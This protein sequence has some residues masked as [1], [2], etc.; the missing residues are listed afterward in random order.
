VH[1]VL[2]KIGIELGDFVAIS[3]PGPIGLLGAQVAKSAGA[4]YVLISGT[5]RD[6]NIR[7]KLASKLGIDYILNVDSQDPVSK[8]RKLTNGTGVDVVIEASGSPLAINQAFQMVRRGGRI[9][10]LGMTE[11]EKVEIPWN[12]GIMKGIQI[13]LPFSS[14]YTSWEK[15]LGLIASK[16]IDAYSLITQRLPLKDWSKAFSLIEKGQAVKVLLI[17]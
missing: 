1:C 7:L 5:S 13:V 2:E 6:A 8:V 9:S 3:G 14:G 15:A 16:K 4:S 10:A 17:P 12:V 11:K